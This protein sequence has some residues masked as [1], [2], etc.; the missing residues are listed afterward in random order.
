MS[1][2]TKPLSMSSSSYPFPCHSQQVMA[3]ELMAPLMAPS[4]AGSG[5]AP[6]DHDACQGLWVGIWARKTASALCEENAFELSNE[7]VTAMVCKAKVVVQSANATFSGDH[8]VLDEQ[9][10]GPSRDFQGS[11]TL[12]KAITEAMWLALNGDYMQ[13]QTGTWHNDSFPSDWNSYVMNLMDP[14]SGMLDP[15]LPPPSFNLT[16]DLFTRSYRKLFV[17]LMGMDHERLLAEAAKDSPAFDAT[18]L[19]PEIRI[20]ISKPMIVLSSTILG[21]YIIVAI[22]VY[23]HRPG[24]FLPR[25][26]LTMASDIALFAASQAVAEI[27]ENE[28]SGKEL[29]VNRKRFGYGSFIGT[30]SRP[31]VGIERAPFVVPA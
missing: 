25:M 20:V 17:I 2:A 5:A 11:D 24:K 31:H 1:C 4:A 26:P 15:A 8:Y 7:E 14:D 30:D 19:H 9:N 28:R 21:L 18:I 3:L 10:K 6:I 22:A 23:V 12:I 27:G 13:D 29:G 16:A